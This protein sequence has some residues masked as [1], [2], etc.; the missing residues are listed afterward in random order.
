MTDL[1][2]PTEPPSAA[3]SRLEPPSVDGVPSVEEAYAREE[4]RRKEFEQLVTPHSRWLLPYASYCLNVMADAEDAMQDVMLRAWMND[5]VALCDRDPERIEAYLLEAM[6]NRVVDQHRQSSRVREGLVGY[7]R[8]LLTETREPEAPDQYALTSD[9]WSHLARAIRKLPA[10]CRE[11]FIL[12]RVLHKKYSVVARVL[13][14][15]VKT[16]DAQVTKGTAL[17]RQELAAVGYYIRRQARGDKK[18]HTS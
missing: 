9:I 4:A 17:V 7:A 5:V 11:A 1:R 14:V 8:S 3:R 2:R 15:D 16:V 10:R 18:E 13:H 12:V 6:H